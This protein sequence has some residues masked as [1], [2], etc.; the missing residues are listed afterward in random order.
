MNQDLGVNQK[1]LK[2]GKKIHLQLE[3][4]SIWKD[5]VK[6]KIQKRSSKIIVGHLAKGI[7][8]HYLLS[9]RASLIGYIK[10]E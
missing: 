8:H 9:V 5:F 7:G 2:R 10:V 3:R 6:N 4:K 1:T